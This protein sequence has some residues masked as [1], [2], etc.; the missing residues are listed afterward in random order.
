MRLVAC[1]LSYHLQQKTFRN[2]CCSL[3]PSGGSGEK[4]PIG[5]EGRLGVGFFAFCFVGS[6]FEHAG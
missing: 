4:R 5:L 6:W 2:I 1:L 3:L